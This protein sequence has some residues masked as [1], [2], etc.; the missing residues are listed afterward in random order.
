[1]ILLNDLYVMHSKL[2]HVDSIDTMSLF[3]K[4]GGFWN[5]DALDEFAKCNKLPSS[6]PLIQIPKFEDGRQFVHDG[7]HRVVSVHMGGRDFLRDD[8][9]VEYE[10]EYEKYIECNDAAFQN[11][12]FTPFDPRTELRHPDFKSFK[13]QAFQKYADKDVTEEA[14]C[15]WIR[16]NSHQ[17]CQQRNGVL[18]VSNLLEMVKDNV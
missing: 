17:Y 5:Q 13:D 8:E 7:H 3:V 6:S 15:D 18:T 9:Y 14:L 16:E 1:M 10:F 11:G 4:N 2:R 12:F